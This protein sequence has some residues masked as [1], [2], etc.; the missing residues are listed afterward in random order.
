MFSDQNRQGMSFLDFVKEDHAFFPL[1][2]QTNPAV[3]A[4]AAASAVGGGGKGAKSASLIRG[5]KKGKKKKKK[6]AQPPPP[7]PQQQQQQQ[8]AARRDGDGERIRRGSATGQVRSRLVRIP[9]AACE[10][11]K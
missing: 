7:P 6:R 5:Q 2:K 1:S 4:A 10:F 3:M 11:L 9:P 8:Q